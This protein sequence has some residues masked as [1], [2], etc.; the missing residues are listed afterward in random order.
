MGGSCRYD[1][2][3][4]REALLRIQRLLNLLQ[5]WV[6]YYSGI[7]EFPFKSCHRNPNPTT[8]HFILH[9]VKGSL[10]EPILDLSR[11]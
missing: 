11:T 1:G 9:Y 4:V 3:R 8:H 5:L 10:P 7:S 6:R 2:L